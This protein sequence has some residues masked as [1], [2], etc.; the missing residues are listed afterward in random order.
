MRYRRKTRWHT[1][2]RYDACSYARDSSLGQLRTLNNPR[3]LSHSFSFSSGRFRFLCQKEACQLVWPLGRVG[4][5]S[6]NL[7]L[8]SAQH[9]L[10]P[11]EAMH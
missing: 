11:G 8:R 9:R 10:R 6:E 5:F 1:S 4:L 3:T 7:G 2:L